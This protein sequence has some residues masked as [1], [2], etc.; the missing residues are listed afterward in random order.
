MQYLGS[1]AWPVVPEYHGLGVEASAF[2]GVSCIRNRGI[3]L[4]RDKIL[5][6]GY[7]RRGIFLPSL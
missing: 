3:I 1:E 5:F 2:P 4:T 6:F 7:L